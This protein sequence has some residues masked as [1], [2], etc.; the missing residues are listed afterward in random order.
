MLFYDIYLDTVPHKIL[1][2]LFRGYL[3]AS[4]LG[5]LK[6]GRLMSDSLY[7]IMRD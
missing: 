1:K 6:S 7:Y 4:W 2:P 5:S 3:E